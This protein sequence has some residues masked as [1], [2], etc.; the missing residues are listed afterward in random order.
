MT[1]RNAAG[2]DSDF[3]V[4]L[5]LA[6]TQALNRRLNR[7]AVLL[8]L[9]ALLTWLFKVPLALQLPVVLA[10]GAAAFAWPV[11]GVQAW[12]RNWIRAYAGLAYETALQLEEA[13][14]DSFGL[15]VTVRAH[16]R[17]AMA[18]ME[19]PQYQSWWLAGVVLAAL[20]LLLPA[21]QFNSP[22]NLT[23]SPRPSP[24]SSAPPAAALQDEEAADAAAEQEAEGTDEADLP[25]PSG[26]REAA[27][28]DGAQGAIDP[29]AGAGDDKAVLDRFLDNLRP[30][31][32]EQDVQ[33]VEAASTQPLGAQAGAPPAGEAEAQEDATQQAGGQ[34]E[35]G[36][37][38]GDTAENA[39]A[40]NDENGGHSTAETEA[41]A[42]SEEGEEQ[43]GGASAGDDATEQGQDPQAGDS[44]M[45]EGDTLDEGGN[46]AGSGGGT[47]D[48][49]GA[50]SSGEPTPGLSAAGEA[51]FLEGQLSGAAANP[52]GSVRLPPF[53]DVEL[54]QGSSTTEFTRAAERAVTEGQVP[55]EYQEIIR[56][57]FRP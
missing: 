11:R 17:T 1:R 53:S 44:A 50:G 18:R 40:A 6:R 16:A 35:A 28:P 45:A 4:H 19:R 10:V 30:R 22:W 5:Q 42:A 27:G 7:A 51:E 37:E 43:P 12:S 54:P 39:A 47:D 46:G 20:V 25:E 38:P 33:Q 34:P 56:N 21:L 49:A 32:P 2:S 29:A 13:P 3:T 24:G 31:P 23:A 14:R 41:A 52:A 9:A 26:R 57:Y 48:S 55:L 36:S 15:R 8:L